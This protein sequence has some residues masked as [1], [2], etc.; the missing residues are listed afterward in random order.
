MKRASIAGLLASLSATALWAH[1]GNG[2]HVHPEELSSL[3]VLVLAV[4]LLAALGGTRRR[5]R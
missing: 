5:S 1:S 4:A 3:V 2:P